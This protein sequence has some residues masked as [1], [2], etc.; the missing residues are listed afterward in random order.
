VIASIDQISECF[1]AR[2][3]PVNKADRMTRR[4]TVPYFGANGQVG[5]IDRALFD[6]PL[7]LVVE[8]ETFTGREIP[9]SYKITGPSWVNNHAHV[10]RSTSAVDVD[11]LNYSLAYYPFT[12]LTTGT[13]GRKKL[14]K[15]ALMGAPYRLPPLAEQKVIVRDVERRLSI[16]E[17]IETALQHA[18]KRCNRL[19]QSILEKAFRGELVPQDPSD[20]PASVLLERIRNER[21][22]IAKPI[23]PSKRTLQ[24]PAK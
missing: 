5:W 9:F 11:Y 21:D 13:T 24:A 18:G 7:I 20:E 6:E 3:V 15:R 8:D 14:T 4:G 12:A 23:R 2:R 22:A 10:L 16:V 17:S 19:R 1:D